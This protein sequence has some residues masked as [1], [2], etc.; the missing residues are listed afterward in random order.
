MGDKPLTHD[1]PV[2]TRHERHAVHDHGRSCG[3][4][5]WGR[6]WTRP[7]MPPLS[8][9]EAGAH[10]P[11]GCSSRCYCTSRRTG[12]PGRD[13]PGDFGALG[14]AVQPLPA[15]GSPPAACGGCFE[16]LTA[17]RP[18]LG[19]AGTRAHRVRPS[20]RLLSTPPGASKKGDATAQGL[21]RSFW[22]GFTGK[23]ILTAADED[24]AM[25]VDVAR[26]GQRR[27]AFGVDGGANL[28]RGDVRST[29]PRGGSRASTGTASGSPACTATSCPTSPTARTAPTPG[30]FSRTG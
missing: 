13:L 17:R 25:A 22:G 23:I 21:G 12:V 4:L 16:L 29:S 2:P 8:G 27:A 9:C 1:F 14:R 24:T 10:A 7:N 15:A 19:G 6:R 11:T 5:A 28:Q 18:D 30:R 20:C 26:P 3:A